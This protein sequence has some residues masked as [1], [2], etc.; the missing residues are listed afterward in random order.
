MSAPDLQDVANE[1]LQR[2]ERHGPIAARDVREALTRAGLDGARWREVVALAGPSL[3]ARRGRYHFQTPAAIRLQQE[4]ERQR[5]IH[6]AVRQVSR[7]HRQAVRKVERRRQGRLDFIQP[8]TV[9]TEDGRSFQLLSRDLST[10]GIRL[11]GTRRLLGQ[12]IRVRVQPEEAAAGCTLLVRILWTCAV[13]DD[14]FENGG[15]FL[16]VMETD[17]DRTC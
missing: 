17:Q 2:A 10:T 5:A 13:G 6:Q 3:V 16:D 8:V 7:L 14:L 9:T 15:A 4:K 12:K 11:I 1:V